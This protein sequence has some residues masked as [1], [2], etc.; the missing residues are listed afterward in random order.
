MSWTFDWSGMW[1]EGENHIG[2]ALISP[3]AP[4]HDSGKQPDLQK[5]SFLARVLFKKVF[6]LFTAA[7]TKPIWLP[8]I[9]SQRGG[10]ETIIKSHLDKLLC[11]HSQS[12]L[13]A[14]HFMCCFYLTYCVKLLNKEQMFKIRGSQ[15]F[16]SHASPPYPHPPPNI[17]S[18]W[19]CFVVFFIKYVKKH[20][21]SDI[22]FSHF[23]SLFNINYIYLV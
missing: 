12:D 13:R 22:F 2:R 5:I 19:C 4:L 1:Q 3:S 8:E 23:H 10:G 20:N 15:M 11:I 14:H 17:I 6:C 21:L 16:L 9:T 7:D 18:F